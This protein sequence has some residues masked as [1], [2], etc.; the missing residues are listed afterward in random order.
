MYM[1]IYVTLTNTYDYLKYSLFALG[2]HTASAQFM[3]LCNWTPTLISD[4][5]SIYLIL[6]QGKYLCEC[7]CVCVCARTC[8]L[9]G[10]GIKS[11]WRQDF[12]YP[13]RPTP[14]AHPAFCMVSTRSSLGVKWL[15]HGADLSPPS[16]IKV[17]NVLELHLCLPLCTFIY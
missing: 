5:Y 7:V 16:S 4:K 1:T 2:P 11:Q 15:G 14:K 3:V 8:M 13:S 9:Y 12:P 17:V 10:P 6:L